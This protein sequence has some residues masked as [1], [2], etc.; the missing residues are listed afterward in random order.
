MDTAAVFET[1]GRQLAGSPDGQDTIGEFPGDIAIDGAGE[2]G[3]GGA[4]LAEEGSVAAEFTVVPG[5]VLIFFIEHA[6]MFPVHI[7][8]FGCPV[9]IGDF[10]AVGPFPDSGNFQIRQTEIG[11]LVAGGSDGGIEEIIFLLA[12]D[13]GGVAA[14]RF[15]PGDN[16]FPAHI[17]AGEEIIGVTAERA[18]GQ[19]E[20]ALNFGIC[21]GQNGLGLRFGLQGG[22][23]FLGSL[24]HLG[25]GGQ[26]F[27][28]DVFCGSQCIVNGIACGFDCDGGDHAK[29]HGQGQKET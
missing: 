12:G 14:Q 24:G 10:F 23:I 22:E 5:S 28:Q 18:V 29:E 13:G 15:T 3:A 21:C 2:G 20:F 9:S 1:L 4:D 11:T 19:G 6:M 25:F 26:D 27:V 7:G 8:L 16:I 17:L